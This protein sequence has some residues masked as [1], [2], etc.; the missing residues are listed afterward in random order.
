[1]YAID[2]SAVT[3]DKV[4]PTNFGGQPGIRVEFSI[5]V[6]GS[7]LQLKGAAWAAEH[8]GQFY[9]TS[10]VAPRLGIFPRYLPYVQDVAKSAVIKG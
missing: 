2:G 7:S 4:E 6:R 1:M 9:A 3:L 8:K 5:V 10:F